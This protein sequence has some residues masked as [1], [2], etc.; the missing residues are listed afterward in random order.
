MARLA[1]EQQLRAKLEALCRGYIRAAPTPHARPPA[2]GAPREGGRGG[3]GA[4]GERACNHA[5]RLPPDAVREREREREREIVCVYGV[6]C[7]LQT[8]RD[9]EQAH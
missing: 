1:R 9:L 7:L 4:A 5:A 6:C 8:R 3:E 2:P